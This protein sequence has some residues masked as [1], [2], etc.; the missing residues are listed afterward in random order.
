MKNSFSHALPNK[1][2]Y[3]GDY[4][5]SFIPPELQAVMDEITQTYLEIREQPEFQAELAELYKHYVGRPSPIFHAKNLSERFGA[6]IYLKREDLN[7]TGAHKINHCL[8]EALL[9]KKL[10]KKKLIAET[11]A[12]QHGVALATAAALVGLECDIYMGEVDIAKEHPN[13]V[14]MAILGANVIPATHGRKTLKEAVDSAFEAYLKDP[15]SQIYCIGSVVGPHPFPMMVRDF[16]SII[17]N[18]AKLQFQEMTH[19]A[20]D[21][22]VAC[23]GGGSNA[24]GIFTAFLDDNAV[25][26]YGVEPTGRNVEEEGEHAATMLKGSPG[27]MHG[28]HSY[29]LQDDAGEPAQVYSVASGLDYPSVGPQHSYL[30]DTARVTYEGISDEEAIQA[31]FDLSRLEGIIPAIESAHA[32]AYACKL[33]TENPG[34]SILVNLSGR[35]DKD[36][37]F[38]VEKY[39]QQYGINDLA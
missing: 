16:Q 24:I 35:G 31:F 29:M 22:I 30:K 6:D 39:G 14:R 25:N 9:A 37:D 38:V 27:T 11:G 26:L 23:V 15:V 5:G 10:G 13:V 2:G 12:G 8:G 19:G 18:E 17:G 32:V 36:I 1:E 21:N 28:F 33:A 7:H 34:S 20:P 4:G 3:F